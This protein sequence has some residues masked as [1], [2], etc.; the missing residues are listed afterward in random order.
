MRRFFIIGIAAAVAFSGTALAARQ[1]LMS[2]QLR[3]AQLRSAPA[4]LSRVLVTVPYTE[5]VVILEE[6][7]DWMRVQSGSTE[8]WM[9]KTA[10]TEKKLKLT[11]SGQDAQLAVSTEE[12][13]LSSKGF[14]AD[15]EKQFKERNPKVDFTAVDKMEKLIIPVESVQKFLADGAVQPAP[16][17]GAR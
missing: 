2:V 17:G 3:E 7:A 1:K 8:G 13:A 16:E 15:V 12:Q 6:K 9:H 4:Y 5:Q 11:G 14:N 10:L